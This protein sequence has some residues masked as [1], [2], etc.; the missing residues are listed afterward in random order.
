MVDHLQLIEQS[1]RA[2]WRWCAT[3]IVTIAI[4]PARIRQGVDD[5]FDPQLPVAY[6]RFQWPLARYIG[7]YFFRFAR[8]VV[9]HF[10]HPKLAWGTFVIRAH[11]FELILMIST[12]VHLIYVLLRQ[13]LADCGPGC[14]RPKTQIVERRLSQI[15]HA[16]FRHAVLLFLACTVFLVT[17]VWPV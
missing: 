10:G 4:A 2:Q 11:T 6:S 16:R 5:W 17:C 12:G 14:E 8:Q 9:N 3:A 1:R 13:D 7:R 15:R